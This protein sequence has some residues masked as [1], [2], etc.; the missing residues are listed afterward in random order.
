MVKSCRYRG[1]EKAIQDIKDCGQSLIDNAEKIVGDYKYLGNVT[2]TCFL[3]MSDDPVHIEVKND[4]YPERYIEG[5][6]YD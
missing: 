1:R 3:E 4:F 6:M 2:I 5:C